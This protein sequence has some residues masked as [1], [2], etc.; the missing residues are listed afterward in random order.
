MRFP[1][2]KI[3]NKNKV[4]PNLL[5]FIHFEESL[6]FFTI[7]TVFKNCFSYSLNFNIKSGNAE[8]F[9]HFCWQYPRHITFLSG[10]ALQ[11]IGNIV[12]EQ[13]DTNVY[14]NMYGQSCANVEILKKKKKLHKKKKYFRFDNI[15]IGQEVMLA[16]EKMA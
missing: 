13:Y 9:P 4:A 8:I 11:M 14:S 6:E 12:D 10:N 15:L 1:K 2:H 3:I 5:F 7:S 16:L